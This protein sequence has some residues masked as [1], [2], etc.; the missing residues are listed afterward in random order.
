MNSKQTAE[1]DVFSR[2]H[3]F[4]ADVHAGDVTE[5]QMAEFEQLLRDSEEAQNLYAELIE[6]SVYLPRALA[7]IEGVTSGQ[8]IVGSEEGAEESGLWSEIGKSEIP[9]QPIPNPPPP[10]SLLLDTPTQPSS[11]PSFVGSWMF[12]NLFSLLVMGLGLF[13][14]WMYQIEIPQPMARVTRPAVIS[15]K[16]YE[17]NDLKF[18]GQV[19][20][21]ADVK[22]SDD[23]T[24]T[25]NGA[26]VPL[27]RKYALASGLMEITYK[28][29][30]KVILQGP[31][32]YKV[33][34]RDGGLLSVGKLTARLEKNV[35]TSPNPQSLIPPHSPLSTLHSPLFTIKTP[36]A[37]VTDLGTEFGV[38]VSRNGIT[39]AHV[40]V[41]R[42][43]IVSS[44]GG[45]S[46]ESARI[47][48]AGDAARVGNLSSR[49]TTT[50][51]NEKRFVRAIPP[52][53]TPV[54]PKDDYASI[55]LSMKPVVYYRMERPKA[56]K[57]Q[58]TLFDS[59][60][61]GHHGKI[62]FDGSPL[63][64]FEPGL[65]GGTLFFRGALTGASAGD[66]VY[67][68]D[69][70]KAI[71]DCFAIS[72]WVMAVTRP[73]WAMIA[74]NWKSA[75][76]G[77]FFLSLEGTDGDLTIHVQQHD[78]QEISVREG[79]STPLPRGQWQHVAAVLDKK[80]LRLY[81]NGVEVA[82]GPCDG[83][84]V[85]A[86]VSHL[87]IGGK[88]ESD[89]NV[90]QPQFWNGRIDELVIFNHSLTHDEILRLYK[91]GMNTK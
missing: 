81:R 63:H 30:A 39:E 33:D 68:A 32:T 42:V 69:Y 60:T 38:E 26:N 78:G 27:D 51:L 90:V 48:C 72:A 35:A 83:V 62:R 9:N 22:W 40:F 59:C 56:E 53:A 36:T 41:G 11:F 46:R 34:S 86:P 12:S 15:S 87:V 18:V 67:I 55:V 16:T 91:P 44:H 74:S 89:G 49:I 20:G 43:S 85:N 6:I 54:T 64:L 75:R 14:A 45:S 8:W 29:G 4:L 23:Q 71:H 70:P 52:Q 61:G 66:C 28:T 65:I 82:H 73:D 37:T 25:I 19:T 24:A 58:F 50:S 77:Q 3:A 47:L 57:D 13:G 84:S 79:S 31:C 5:A 2:V 76:H 21:M 1:F 7:G 17:T 88:L 80:V 10:V